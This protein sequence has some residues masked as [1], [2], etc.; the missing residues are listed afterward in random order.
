M[1]ICVYCDQQATPENPVKIWNETGEMVCKECRL[2]FIEQEFE[3]LHQDGERSVY[4]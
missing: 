4:V 2:A 1:N 3:R